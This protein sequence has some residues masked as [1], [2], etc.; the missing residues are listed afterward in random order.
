MQLTMI[1]GNLLV[2]CVC[3]C[4]RVIGKFQLMLVASCAIDKTAN[5]ITVDRGGGNF[6]I[7]PM[8]CVC[9]YKKLNNKTLNLKVLKY[10]S[11][12]LKVT[13]SIWQV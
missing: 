2:V 1:Q 8:R 4:V 13:H 7:Y 12:T 5:H 3:V 6:T 10:G 11:M 9:V